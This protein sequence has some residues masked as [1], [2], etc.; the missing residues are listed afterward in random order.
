M[1]L[2]ILGIDP[3]LANTGWA[4]IECEGSTFRSRGFGAIRTASSDPLPQRLRAIH[5]ALADLIEREGPHEC[6]IENV[7]FSK[8]VQ[9]AFA[10]GQARGVAILATASADIPVEEYGPS[11]IKQAVTGYGAADKRQIQFMIRKMLALDADPKP[12]HAADA[13]AVAVCH[14][15][16]RGI[17]RAT[18]TADAGGRR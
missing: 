3:G 8:N 6:A 16:G 15:N 14:A 18:A 11:E 2:V 1:P 13:L 17:R 5:D 12:D 7:Y 4:L 10:T 9:T